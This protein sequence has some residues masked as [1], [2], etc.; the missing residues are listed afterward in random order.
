MVAQIADIFQ[1]YDVDSA[2]YT[3]YNTTENSLNSLL[4]AAADET[5][6]RSLR[7]KYIGYA[8]I[9][10]KDMLEQLYIAYIRAFRTTKSI[11][12]GITA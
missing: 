3:K 10:T 6:I 8:N 2:L 12:M 7:D 11:C 9:T 5:Y 1:Q 4:I